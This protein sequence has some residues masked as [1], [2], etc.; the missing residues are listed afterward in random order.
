VRDFSSDQGAKPREYRGYFEVLQTQSWRKDP[1]WAR[2][3]FTTGCWAAAVAARNT[4][5]SAMTKPCTTVLPR[6]LRASALGALL[7]LSPALL[8]ASAPDLAGTVQDVTGARLPHA[9]VL[10]RNAITG[11][12][13]LAAVDER[14]QF[15]FAGLAPGRYLIGAR[16]QGFAAAERELDAPQVAQVSLSLSPAPV[17][18]QL[19]VVSGSRQEELRENLNARVDVLSRAR[20]QDTGYTSAGEA[21]RE[22]PGVV[23]RRGSLGSGAA[24]QQVQGIDSRQVLV[25]L[26]GQPLVGARGIKRGAIDLDRQSTGRLERIEVVKGASSALHGSDAI[27]GVINLVTREAQHALER[28]LD[29][30]GGSLGALDVRGE[31]GFARGPWRGLVSLERHAGDG[32]DLTPTTPDRTG[33]AFERHDA[34]VKLH[35]AVGTKLT[36]D[37]FANSY[38]NEARTRVVGE[39]GLQASDT[40]DQAGN[41]G[42]TTEWRPGPRTSV[43]ARGYHARYD[44]RARNTLLEVAAPAPP[45][46][47]LRERLGKV[48]ATLAHVIGERQFVQLGVEWWRDTYAGVNRLRDADG[49]QATTAVVWA[50]D[51]LHLPGNLTLTGGVR[52][53]RHSVFGSALSPKLALGLRATETLRLRASYGRGFRAP[54]LGQL[55]Y[56]FLNPTNLYQVLGNPNLRPEH[57]DSYQLGA[58]YASRT[59]RWRAGVNVFRND[60][61]ELIEAVNLGFVASPA[62]LA[63]LGAREGLQPEFRPVLGRLLFLYKNVAD[64]RTQGIELDTEASLPAGFALSG[65]YTYLDARDLTSALALTGRHR[66]QGHARL[67]WQHARSGTRVNLRAT[68][69]SAWIA[70]R[71]TRAGGSVDTVAPAFQLWDIYAAQRLGRDLEAFAAVDNLTDSRDPNAGLL[72]PR[73]QPLP[74]YRAEVGRT[75]RVGLRWARVR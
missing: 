52:V 74:V 38:W 1:L 7:L 11:F 20:L 67:A 4:V 39:Q 6:S 27:G 29:L 57:A 34:Y 45:D 62:Q 17:V 44:E 19:M 60:V 61:R 75:L 47:E 73:S 9:V 21:L 14:G 23:T 56:R 63:A 30:S 22:L 5:R 59:R 16:A 46:D 54:D 31:L 65:A 58:E 18:E 2:S 13:R 64:A 35:R 71:E 25:L 36:L 70:T 8:A 3:D 68:F 10:L 53:D 55:Y 66:H 41:F 33:A 49:E 28:R 32:F 43:Q 42:V 50:Q 51:R 40:H 26:D 69:F 24:G 37:A 15:A 12:E 72:D 48:D